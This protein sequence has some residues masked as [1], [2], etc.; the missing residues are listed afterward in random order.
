[1]ERA[2]AIGTREIRDGSRDTRNSMVRTGGKGQRLRGIVQE[3]A[4]IGI[5]PP[6]QCPTARLGVTAHTGVIRESLSLPVPRLL[7]ARANRG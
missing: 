4:R 3:L 5:H 2:N 6:E 7:D 1:M